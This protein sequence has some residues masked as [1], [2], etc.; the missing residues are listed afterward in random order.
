MHAARSL[1]RIVARE[2]CAQGIRG[3]ARGPRG[4]HAAER[5]LPRGE[6][7]LELAL[8]GCD[9]SRLRAQLVPL[10]LQ[11]R[12]RTVRLRDGALRLA[13]RIPDLRAD[14]LPF[15]ELGGEG[16]DARPQGLQ[17]LLPGAGRR[18][19]EA[20]EQQDQGA[21]QGRALPCADTAATRFASSSASPR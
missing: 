7:P 19:G 13:Q 5:R 11:E 16:V 6:L 4:E 2:R 20:A 14:F 21:D 3:P 12:E 18:G 1:R 9:R 17:I 8:L 10:E 15:L